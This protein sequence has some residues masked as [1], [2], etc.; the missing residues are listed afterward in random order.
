MNETG[1]AAA[2]RV[3]CMDPLEPKYKLVTLPT[4]GQLAKSAL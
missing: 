2:G 3:A 1:A 4:G